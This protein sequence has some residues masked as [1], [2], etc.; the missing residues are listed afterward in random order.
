MDILAHVYINSQDGGPS[1]DMSAC[2]SLVCDTHNTC[3]KCRIKRK[4]DRIFQDS[5]V[6]KQLTSDI[7]FVP[8]VPVWEQISLVLISMAYDQP[9]EGFRLVL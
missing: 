2:L 1:R 6:K 4:E 3:V 8:T 9:P 5:I 7:P